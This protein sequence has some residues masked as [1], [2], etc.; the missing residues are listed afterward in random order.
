MFPVFLQTCMHRIHQHR[1]HDKPAEAL[2]LLHIP[3]PLSM[4]V[5]CKMYTISK[6]KMLPFQTKAFMN[7]LLL[8][9]KSI[10]RG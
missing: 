1:S 3:L 4:I 8:K 2:R 9:K 10:K 7:G 6:K 5:P